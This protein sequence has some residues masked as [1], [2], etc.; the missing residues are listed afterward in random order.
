MSETR[1]TLQA[2][3]WAMT[4]FLDA[5]THLLQTDRA[6]SELRLYFYAVTGAGW[7][8][9]SAAADTWK[10]AIEGRSITAYVGTDHALTDPA[11]LTAMRDGSVA[12][13]L[14]RRYNGVYHPKVV[15]FVENGAGHL[16][17][18]SNNLTQDG[19]KNNIEFATL[20]RLAGPDT[21]LNAWHSAVHAGSDPVDDELLEAYG[22]EREAFG[23]ARAKAKVAGTFTW[24][25]RTSAGTPPS[26]P[27]AAP[28]RGVVA[29]PAVAP[30][31]PAPR[32]IAPAPAAPAHAPVPG[33]GAPVRGDL[34]LEI[35]PRETGTGGNQIQAP[36]RAAKS[37]FGLGARPNA[38]V[39]VSLRNVL[40]GE[41]RSLTM[42]RFS[43]ST[44][45]LVIRE[46]DYRDRPCVVQFRRTAQATFDFEIVR[47][48]IDPT[49]YRSLIQRCG[50]PT[51]SGSRRWIQLTEALSHP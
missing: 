7:R 10:R 33:I 34:V 1:P 41:D 2:A 30:R 5:A 11:A 15:W 6:A 14:L 51:R 18:G 47:E 40:T 44:A 45:R 35:M 16:L 9:L 32:P 22:T 25:K 39:A 37:F 28:A 42:T 29:A 4:G 23:E 46:L 19:L 3:A 31:A 20:T 27:A 36:M 48:S 24:S 17:V 8:E 26:A 38:Q 12:I 13:R 43:N 49:R 21:N 50:T